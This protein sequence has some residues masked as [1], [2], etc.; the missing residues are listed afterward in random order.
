MKKII[1]TV[2]V[3]MFIVGCESPIEPQTQPT[4]IEKDN[5]EYRYKYEFKNDRTED[6]NIVFCREY[7]I[8]KV[9]TDSKGKGYSF[10][11]T[12]TTF[13]SVLV[14]VNSTVSIGSDKDTLMMSPQY[15]LDITDGR[16][17]AIEYSGMIRKL[18]NDEY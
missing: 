2:L 13:D 11:S 4:G 18:S 17:R 14:P 10:D 15:L 8:Y 9:V 3:G 1:A 7:N 16:F 5:N 12:L 6:A